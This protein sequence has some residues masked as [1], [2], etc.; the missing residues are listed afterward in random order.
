MKGLNSNSFWK[1]SCFE[2]LV[3]DFGLHMEPQPLPDLLKLGFPR[4]CYFNCQKI[5][6][7]HPNLIYCEG[8]ALLSNNVNIEFPFPHAWL[9][10]S[11]GKAINPTWETPGV[12]YLGAQYRTKKKGRDC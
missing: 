3:L 11:E 8:Y 5:I 7:Q 1:Y 4:N 12:A 10:S 2:K 9:M 6:E